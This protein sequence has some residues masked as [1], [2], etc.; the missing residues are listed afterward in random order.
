LKEEICD[1]V[2]IGRQS[3]ADPL[4]AKKIPESKS[5]EVN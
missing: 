2:G 3:L 1:P 5:A 4:F